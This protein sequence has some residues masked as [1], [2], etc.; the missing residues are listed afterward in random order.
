MDRILEFILKGK[1]ST[2]S[3]IIAIAISSA[4]VSKRVTQYTIQTELRFSQIESQ[5]PRVARN[6]WS[7]V[8]MEFYN[9]ELKRLKGEPV[10]DVG[11]I[12]DAVGD[13]F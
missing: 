12:M 4:S 5:L 2:L 8:H 9:N 6:R 7:S 1:G 11:K 13:N 10:P 3:I